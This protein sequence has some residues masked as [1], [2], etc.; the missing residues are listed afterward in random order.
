MS[1]A[2]LDRYLFRFDKEPVLQAARVQGDFGGY[3]LDADEQRAV[4]DGDLATLLEWG[5]HPLLIRN[6]GAVIGIR[7]VDA[8]TAR[9]W[10][11]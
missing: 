1:R 9:G 7:Y 8:Y 2:A 6:F 11:P 10:M 3:D 4:L 5:V